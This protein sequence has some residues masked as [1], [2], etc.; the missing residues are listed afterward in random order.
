M[1]RK[2]KS[3]DLDL[4]TLFYVRFQI[5]NQIVTRRTWWNWHRFSP[6]A[7]RMRFL[8]LWR[9]KRRQSNARWWFIRWV[10]RVRETFCRCSIYPDSHNIFHF[11]HTIMESCQTS[12]S[13]TT[14]SPCVCFYFVDVFLMRNIRVSWNCVS[15][16]S[17]LFPSAIHIRLH[18]SFSSPNYFHDALFL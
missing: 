10:F 5:L 1:L 15:C 8:M 16:I 9:R 7:A 2:P 18:S 14:A 4:Q 6:T 12:T 11:V 13:T 17:H 3:K